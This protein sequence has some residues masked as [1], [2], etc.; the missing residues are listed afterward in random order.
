[1]LAVDPLRTLSRVL[2]TGASVSYDGSV[3][4]VCSP[5]TVRLL[6]PCDGVSTDSKSSTGFHHKAPDTE[7]DP[8]PVVGIAPIAGIHSPCSALFRGRT[9]KEEMY[10]QGSQRT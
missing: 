9:S 3:I 6:G 8:L 4:S 5:G 2:S 1:M 7:R 10:T